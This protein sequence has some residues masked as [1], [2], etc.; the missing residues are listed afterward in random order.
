MA[1]GGAQLVQQQADRRGFPRA[2]RAQEAEDLPRVHLKV[3]TVNRCQVTKVLGE[4]ARADRYLSHDLGLLVVVVAEA[5]VPG[6]RCRRRPRRSAPATWAT[7]GLH[8][9]RGRCGPAWP[10]R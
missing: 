8:R 2:V 7:G 3:N 1:R 9:V 4:P 10:E 5:V 6:S